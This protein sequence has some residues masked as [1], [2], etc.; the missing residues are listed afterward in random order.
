MKFGGTSVMDAAAIDRTAQIVRGRLSRRPAV[1]V[2]AMSKV[3][4]ALLAAG[5]A[6]GEGKRSSRTGARTA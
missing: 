1:V 5:K 6:A 2:S 4:D 3:T